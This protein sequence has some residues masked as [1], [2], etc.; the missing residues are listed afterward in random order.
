MRIPNIYYI[1]TKKHNK[2]RSCVFKK[3]NLKQTVETIIDGIYFKFCS[4]YFKVY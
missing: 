2:M 3:K 4:D 1:Y